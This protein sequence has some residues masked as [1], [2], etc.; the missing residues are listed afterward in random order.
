MLKELVRENE[1]LSIA[2]SAT[3]RIYIGD[4]GSKLRIAEMVND[5][6][7]ELNTLLLNASR[8]LSDFARDHKIRWLS[9]LRSDNY[10]EFSN[11]LWERLELPSPDP[12]A[13]AFW[14]RRQPSWDAV[15]SVLDSYGTKGVILVEAKSH[16]RE[17]ES[18]CKA[19][20]AESRD[21]IVRS[22]ER[23][24]RY[25]GVDRDIEWT[26]PYYQ[27]AN[28]Y[29]FLYYLRAVRNIPAWL[30]F[31]Y[32]T[33]DGFEVDGVAQDCPADAAHWRPALEQLHSGLGLPDSHPLT[34]FTLELFPSVGK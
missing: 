4:R 22:M 1:R 9:P 8:T 14:P 15:G 6:P 28:R 7:S 5:R 2:K 27:G 25:I 19:S 33:G 13:D 21:L 17:I 3:G 11:D 12:H 18:T 31:L 32:F 34:H 23:A 29:S 10:R 20:S 24:K 16:I 30:V 26:E